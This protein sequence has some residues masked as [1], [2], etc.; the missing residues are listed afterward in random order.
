MASSEIDFFPFF[1]F[2]FKASYL[3]SL[4]ALIDFGILYKYMLG[5][6]E[7]EEYTVRSP[8]HPLHIMDVLTFSSVVGRSDFARRESFESECPLEPPTAT[9]QEQY[10]PHAS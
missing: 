2:F 4:V 10:R 3:L 7:C 1:L 9:V 8:L 6:S 5:F